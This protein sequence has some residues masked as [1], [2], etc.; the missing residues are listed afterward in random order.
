MGRMPPVDAEH[1]HRW[2]L[3]MR[4]LG[5]AHSIAPNVFKSLRDGLGK[6]RPP[7]PLAAE[8]Y[9]LVG[10]FDSGSRRAGQWEIWPPEVWRR[11]R[12]PKVQAATEAI[13]CWADYWNLGAV[14]WFK[15]Y[16]LRLCVHWYQLEDERRALKLMPF[17]GLDFGA[18]LG[19]PSLPESLPLWIPGGIWMDDPQTFSERLRAIEEGTQSLAA[20]RE[21]HIVLPEQI[22]VKAPKEYLG[23]VERW[24]ELTEQNAAKMG[25][26]EATQKR[27]PAHFDWLALRVCG[28][29]GPAQI[30]ILLELYRNADSVQEAVTTLAEQLELPLP[31]AGKQKKPPKHVIQRLGLKK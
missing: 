27:E 9:R 3:R 18:G 25:W 29:L 13:D 7:Y 28:G 6:L 20:D 21:T 16:A 22:H 4:F 15:N 31:S 30:V 19:L 12:F 2:R 8:A 23:V 24:I 11:P 10:A 17:Y 26:A 5:A 14:G 1:N